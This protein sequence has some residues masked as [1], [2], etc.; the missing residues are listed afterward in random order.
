MSTP[1]RAN[2]S[3]GNPDKVFDLIE[4]VGGG[5]YGDVFK[6]GLYLLVYLFWNEWFLRFRYIESCFVACFNSTQWI[7]N[8]PP[9]LGQSDCYRRTIG[10]ESCQDWAR[11]VEWLVNSKLKRD[12][13]LFLTAAWPFLLKWRRTIGFIALKPNSSCVYVIFKCHLHHESSL[14]LN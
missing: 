5:T 10:G 2:I 12:L 14:L 3:R 11:Q 4:K 6:V 1:L 7:W 13:S 9:T 8:L